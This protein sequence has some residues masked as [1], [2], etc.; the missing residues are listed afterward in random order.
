MYRKKKA[1]D[2]VNV[3]CQMFKMWSFDWECGGFWDSMGVTL[4]EIPSSW[5]YGD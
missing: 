5:G 1:G 4:A 3:Q 2:N